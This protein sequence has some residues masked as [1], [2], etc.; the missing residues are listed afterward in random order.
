MTDFQVKNSHK[1][2][3]KNQA[4]KLS[5]EIVAEFVEIEL[6]EKNE[7]QN[8]KVYL[9]LNKKLK[10]EVSIDIIREKKMRVQSLTPRRTSRVD[11]NNQLQSP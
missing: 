11:N 5:S 9:A 10:T 3:R 8:K 4:N 6:T 7:K 2:E 1:R